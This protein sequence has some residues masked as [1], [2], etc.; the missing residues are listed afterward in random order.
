MF[1]LQVISSL[2]PNDDFGGFEP[3][4]LQVIKMKDDVKLLSLSR[5]ADSPFLFSLQKPGFYEPKMDGAQWVL[6]Q[7]KEEL[8]WI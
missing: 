2:I 5:L 6:E 7:F 4:R 3:L 1:Y 8:S